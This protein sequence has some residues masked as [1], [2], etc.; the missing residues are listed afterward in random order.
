MMDKKE[1]EHIAQLSHLQLK[2]KDLEKLGQDLV[3]ILDYIDQLKKIDISKVE[4]GEE[5]EKMSLREDR[6]QLPLSEASQL[7]ALAPS[8]QG[9]HIKVQSI[10]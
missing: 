1:I 3:S 6:V 7:L 2:D 10:F 4:L 8:S 5:A 9:P